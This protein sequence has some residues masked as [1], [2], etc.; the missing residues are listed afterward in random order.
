M[1]QESEPLQ[2]KHPE[3]KKPEE[4]RQRQTETQICFALEHASLGYLY[5]AVDSWQELFGLHSDLWEIRSVTHISMKYCLG[6]VPCPSSC[7]SL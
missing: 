7:T 3:K 2:S 1:A 6:I 4:A 5:G